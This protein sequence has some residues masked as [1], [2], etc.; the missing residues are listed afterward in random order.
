MGDFFSRMWE[1]E[2]SK[3][4]LTLD[5]WYV[6]AIPMLIVFVILVA[7]KYKRIILSKGSSVKMKKTGNCWLCKKN[8]V[9]GEENE[10]STTFTCN[11]CLVIID[12]FNSIGNE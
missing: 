4:Q 11:E 3:L 9:E 2:A 7:T 1:I 5:Y 12:K 8:D 10:I 6:I